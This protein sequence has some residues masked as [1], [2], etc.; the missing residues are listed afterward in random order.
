[1]HNGLVHI[2]QQVMYKDSKN[3]AHAME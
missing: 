3:I 1:M 2:R